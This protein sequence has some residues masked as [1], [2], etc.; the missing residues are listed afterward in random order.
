MIR[1]RLT[2]HLCFGQNKMGKNQAETLNF[3]QPPL[4]LKATSYGYSLSV[5]LYYPNVLIP[6]VGPDLEGTGA[7][8]FPAIRLLKNDYRAWTETAYLLFCSNWR[9]GS[10][11]QLQHIPFTWPYT[12]SKKVSHA[13]L[14]NTRPTGQ[15]SRSDNICSITFFSQTASTTLKALKV[16]AQKIH[17]HSHLFSLLR[18]SIKKPT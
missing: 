3:Y 16:V 15:L 9:Y 4:A 13:L 1:S 17:F 7:S 14:L 2:D 11:I 18:A 10:F 12:F 5:T 8:V 6:H